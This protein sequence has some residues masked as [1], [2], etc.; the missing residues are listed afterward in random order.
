MAVA[1][2]VEVAADGNVPSVLVELSFSG[3]LP[4]PRFRTSEDEENDCGS[5]EDRG[6][7]G[8]GGVEEVVLSGLV[9]FTEPPP[10][11]SLGPKV[12]LRGRSERVQKRI[13]HQCFKRGRSKRTV[14]G[15]LGKALGDAKAGANAQTKAALGREEVHAAVQCLLQRR[16]KDSTREGAVAAV[17]V[18]I[19]LN[20]CCCLLLPLTAGAAAL[21]S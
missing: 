19:R 21:C 10:P 17:V 8:L 3:V 1:D 9:D 11:F 18:R 16:A 14:L 13:S 12:E 7:A 20:I 6:S 2:G 5:V 15:G 4:L